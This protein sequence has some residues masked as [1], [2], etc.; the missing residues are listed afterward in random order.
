MKLTVKK[1]LKRIHFVSDLHF[2]HKNIINLCKRPYRSLKHMHDDL[3]HKWNSVVDKGD[4]V[5]H[6]GD[7]SY[8]G[9]AEKVDRILE[10]LNG[11]IIFI[12]GNHESDLM[13]SK[14]RGT[15]LIEER[16]ELNIEGVNRLIVL[17]HYPMLAWN[18][19]HSGSIQLFGHVHG[20]LSN[21]GVIDH[22]WNQMDVGID[23]TKLFRPI[24]AE[25]VL[26]RI[27]QQFIDLQNKTLA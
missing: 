23:A 4:T 10:Q 2:N 20:G 3:I 25:E 12:K 27:T 19:S 18:K 9:S 16:I 8:K 21:K 5:F 1:D 17:D 15:H 7:F 11:E 6:L 14:A 26:E 22:R 24:N 13:K